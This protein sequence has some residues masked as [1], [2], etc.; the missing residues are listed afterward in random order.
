MFDFNHN[1][2]RRMQLRKDYIDARPLASLLFLLDLL[3][4][5][6]YG[7]MDMSW[8]FQDYETRI[9]GKITDRYPVLSWR[10]KKAAS[11]QVYPNVLRGDPV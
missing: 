5:V 7:E 1:E 8:R 6:S 11:E 2:Y 3:G 9:L 4:I 10:Q